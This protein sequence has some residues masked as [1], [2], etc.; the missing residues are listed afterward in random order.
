[1]NNDSGMMRSEQTCNQSED[2][3]SGAVLHGLAGMDMRPDACVSHA[4]ISCTPD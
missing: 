2:A 4:V 1:M 3:I